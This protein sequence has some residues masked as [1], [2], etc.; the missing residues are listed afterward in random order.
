MKRLVVVAVRS[1]ICN[2]RC[3]YC[4]LNQKPIWFQNKQIEYNYSPEH[5]RKCLSKKRLGGECLFNF[6]SDGETL[7]AKNITEYVKAILLEGHYVEF[8][9]NLS[10]TSV[11]NEMLD[12]DSNLL[13]RLEFKC[14][15]HYLQLKERNLLNVFADNV[16]NI[17][18]KGASAC[19]EI[20][21]DDELIPYIDEVKAFSLR[22]FG[23]LPHLTIARNDKRK[24]DFLT[25]LSIDEYKKTWG[26]FDSDFWNFKMEI[27][28][29]KM[30]GYCFAGRRSIYVDLASGNTTQCYRSRYN[31]NIFENPDDDIDFCSIG[32]CI[33]SYC[34]NGHAFLT[35]GIVPSF[36]APGYGNIRNR[37]NS[38]TGQPW[39]NK[40][41]LSFMNSK[42]QDEYSK[43][44][45]INDIKK[46][47]KRMRLV[48]F[49][50]MI[51]KI[52]R[53]H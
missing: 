8:V 31:F 30:T 24:H 13:E 6:C 51:N 21:P 52:K 26:V 28:N 44:E 16:H 25:S 53:K 38:N 12:W 41:M 47:K 37:I 35:C 1:S 29:K 49:R 17:W 39:I 19:I 3:R 43:S 10:V 50:A 32:K 45:T 2:F 23:A 11:L 36:P 40:K 22:E 18:K 20:T 42:T 48:N 7:L 9:T 4:Y 14:S 34:Y 5:V 27:V 15:F 33:D 46:D